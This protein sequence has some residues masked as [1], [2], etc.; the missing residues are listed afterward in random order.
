MQIVNNYY[1]L[2]SHLS[3]LKKHLGIEFIEGKNESTG[4]YILYIPQNQEIWIKE[5]ENIIYFKSIITTLDIPA[6]REDFF[7]YLMKA[8]F[9][10]QGTGGSIISIDPDEKFFYLS[11]CITYDINYKIFRDKLEDFTNYL[12]YWRSELKRLIVVDIK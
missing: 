8:N 11:L 4:Y 2:K 1:M 9:L 12:D 6:N 3:D 10:G 5:K 7:I